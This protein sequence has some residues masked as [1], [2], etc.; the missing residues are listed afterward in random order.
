[1]R[2]ALSYLLVICLLLVC[3]GCAQKEAETVTDVSSVVSQK[4][5]GS[6]PEES[7]VP[8]KQKEESKPKES[9]SKGS[10]PFQ[11]NKKPQ[12]AES[13][14][15]TEKQDVPKKIQLT[16]KQP[17]KTPKV[18]SQALTRG[19]FLAVCNTYEEYETF[20]RIPVKN[21]PYT[22]EYFD[23]GSL[24]IV[25]LSTPDTATE[26]EPKDLYIENQI[27][28]MEWDE[29][30]VGPGGAV[31]TPWQYFLEVK[32]PIKGIEKALFK[33]TDWYCDEKMKTEEYTV[34]F[35]QPDSITVEQPREKEKQRVEVMEANFQYPVAVCNSYKE[36]KEYLPGGVVPFTQ[37]DWDSGNYSLLVFLVSASDTFQTI[38]PQEV[39]VQG[40]TLHV[41]WDKYYKNSIEGTQTKDYCYFWF[42]DRLPNLTK[43][44]V[45]EL[46]YLS[47]GG[48]KVLKDTQENTYHI[49][50]KN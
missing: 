2:K 21:F 33:I 45:E 4:A 11:T 30:S 16:W 29:K 41:K 14:P 43:V 47:I 20:L 5:E 32:E 13:K 31:S 12:K 24:V 25:N 10:T 48:G 34:T 3:A 39:R 37:Q 8:E 46:S 17:E 15:K 7:S 19:F 49:S 26:F 36:L 44:H 28:V 23:H 1:M 6:E 27:L 50:P 40:D 42:T 9:S 18:R 38:V 22:K 35:N